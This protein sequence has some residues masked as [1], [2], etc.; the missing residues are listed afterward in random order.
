MNTPLPFFGIGAMRAG[1]TWLSRV[2]DIHPDCRMT[3]FK[4]LHFFDTRYGK[5]SGNEYYSWLA[6]SIESAGDRVSEIL[7]RALDQL[8]SDGAVRGTAGRK[9]AGPALGNSTGGWSDATRTDLFANARTDKTLSRISDYV[10]IFFLRNT[11]SYADYVRRSTLGATA[12][13]E[14]TPSYSLLPAAAFAEMDRTLPGARFIFI[15]RDPVE[16]LWSQARYRTGNAERLHGRQLKPEDIF[17][18]LLLDQ[19]ATNRSD[20]RRTIG[21]LE[22]VIPADR[23]LYFFYETM[24]SAE[25]GPAEIRRMEDGLGLEHADLGQELF[26]RPVNASAPASL[27]RKQE[28]AAVDLFR[29]VYDFVEKRFGR[30]PGWRFDAAAPGGIADISERTGT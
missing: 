24:T 7:C 18:K 11:D 3:P 10:E 6:R 9:G 16:R 8:Q 14:M 12:F 17:D 1:T 13:G 4:E 22:S 19:G 15:M 26:N 20:Y 29:P 21:E 30:L 2:L 28:A 5:F 25:T 23:I 27:S